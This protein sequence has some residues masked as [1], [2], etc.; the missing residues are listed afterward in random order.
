MAHSLEIRHPFLD[1]R[2]VDF[3][4]ALPPEWKIRNGWSKYVLRLS[5]P[6]LPDGIR[7]RRDKQGFVTPEE[8]WLKHDFK[9]LIRN[10]FRDSKLGELG[11]I[12][13][14]E[15]L[16]YYEKF[17]NGSRIA[18]TDISRALVAELWARKY[19]N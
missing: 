4:V 6:G 17:Q 1:H 10:S 7:W 8:R 5:V 9:D 19:L 11:M 12:N 14:S 16:R 18:Y 3:V 15:F 2:L 13:E